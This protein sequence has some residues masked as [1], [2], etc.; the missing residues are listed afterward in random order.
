[1]KKEQEQESKNPNHNTD[2]C[3]MM[4]SKEILKALD[5][6]EERFPNLMMYETVDYLVRVL[7]GLAKAA[8]GNPNSLRDI[9]TAAMNLEWDLRMI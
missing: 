7:K 6:T 9:L 5:I 8:N 3:S 2:D 1:M 4:T